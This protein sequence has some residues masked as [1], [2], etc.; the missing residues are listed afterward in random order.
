MSIASAQSAATVTD[1]YELIEA[2]LTI[3]AALQ[4]APLVT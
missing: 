3:K 1:S 2:D 4:E